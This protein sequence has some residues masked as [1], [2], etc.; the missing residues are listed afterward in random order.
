MEWR[1]IFANEAASGGL[2][3]KIQ[4]HLM[5]QLFFFLMASPMSYRS[6]QAK[7]WIPAA[8][9]TYAA[10]I[11]MPEALTHWSGLG[12]KLMLPQWPEPLQ[13]DS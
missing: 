3:S 8:A 13:L 11:A 10:A 4:K 1:K 9:A 12:T 5:Q 6:S 2:I 7:D